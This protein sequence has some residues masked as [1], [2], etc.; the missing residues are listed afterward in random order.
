MNRSRALK[1]PAWW[2]MGRREERL[3]RIDDEIAVLRRDEH[4]AHEELIMLGHLTEDAQ[5]DAAGGSLLGA[6]DAR[7][8]AGDVARMERHVAHL[9]SAREHLERKRDQM[10][11][12]LGSRVAG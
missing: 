3:F 7:E 6:T 12:K 5:R 11:T 9:R 2:R 4:D 8:A 10:P 1:E